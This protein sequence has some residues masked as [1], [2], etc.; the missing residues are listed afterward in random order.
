MI[1]EAP[2]LPRLC[3]GVV[4]AG[5]WW[6]WRTWCLA[7]ALRKP[8]SEPPDL[9]S[10]LLSVTGMERVTLGSCW[11]TNE[12]TWPLPS[13]WF[14]PF[15]YLLAI[16]PEEWGACSQHFIPDHANKA[17]GGKKRL[18]CDGWFC[19]SIICFSQ[20]RVGNTFL[21]IYVFKRAVLKLR[22]GRNILVLFNLE[23]WT[24]R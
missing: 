4:G 7:E 24:V 14:W 15:H 9:L 20:E 8:A 17:R 13:L 3:R 1:H 22:V 2:W 12:D 16:L 23:V 6:C 21:E 11:L 5:W 10:C 19:V 18:N